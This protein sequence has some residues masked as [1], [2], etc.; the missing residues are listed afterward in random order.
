MPT[1]DKSREQG[2]E[3]GSFAEELENEEYPIDKSEL[4]ETYGDREIKLQ[5]GDQTLRE[6]LDPLGETKFESAKD[7]TQ[8]VIGMV[9]DEAIGRKNYSDRGGQALKGDSDEESI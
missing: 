3:F 4:L 6:V 9:D 7:V 8:S 2:V 5:D 1:S